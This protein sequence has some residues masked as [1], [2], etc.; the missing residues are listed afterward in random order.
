MFFEAQWHFGVWSTLETQYPVD[1]L[2]RFRRTSNTSEHAESLWVTARYFHS[3]MQEE[4]AR[5]PQ[6]NLA[7]LLPYITDFVEFYRKKIGKAREATFEVSN[8]G[9]FTQEQQSS[10]WSLNNMTFTQGALPAGPAFAVNC[11][12]VQGGP[13]TITITWQHSVVDEAIIDAV[14]QGFAEL[15]I[16]L[17]GRAPST[18]DEIRLH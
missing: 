9:V 1:V 14:A 17:D 3:Q 13:L 6:D 4:L 10:E 7:G 18:I 8:V 11:A 12:S 15:P 16:L 2:D 5:C